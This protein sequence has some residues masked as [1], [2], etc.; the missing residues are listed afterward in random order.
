MALS[1]NGWNVIESQSSRELVVIKIPNTGIPGIPLRVQKDCAPLLAYVA[2]RVH[3][4]VCDLRKNNKKGE[5]KKKKI[6]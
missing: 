3:E 2:S 1:E 5:I 4:E 6:I